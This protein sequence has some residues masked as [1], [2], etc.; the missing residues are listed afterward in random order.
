MSLLVVSEYRNFDKMI[1]LEQKF[2]LIFFYTGI[3][4]LEY[5]T[6]NINQHT[7]TKRKEGKKG[8]PTK[9]DNKVTT[10]RI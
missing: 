9:D 2:L 7:T 8:G 10:I 3:V 5:K 6:T 1:G 4:I